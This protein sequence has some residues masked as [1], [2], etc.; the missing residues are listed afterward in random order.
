MENKVLAYKAPL[1]GRTTGQLKVEP[2]LFYVAKK[3]FENYSYEDQVIAYSVFGG[4]PAY[5]QMI[6][7]KKTIKENIVDNILKGQS[8]LFEEPLIFLKEEFR[9]PALYNS[10]VEAIANG[11]TKLNDIATKIGITT[12]KTSNYLKNLLDLQIVKKNTNY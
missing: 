4:I 3:Y 1:Y 12:G 7:N 10:I 5:L 8:Y 6:D 11:S 2:F 9:E